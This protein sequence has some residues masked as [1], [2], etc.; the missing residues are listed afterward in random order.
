MLKFITQDTIALGVM[1]LFSARLVPTP[2]SRQLPVQQLVHP[3]QLVRMMHVAWGIFLFVLMTVKTQDHIVLEEMPS[4]RAHQVATRVQ[5]EI[6]DVLRVLLVNMT[7]NGHCV[8]IGL[9]CYCRGAII[10]NMIVIAHTGYYC[11]GGS[12]LTQ[13]A[14]GTYST[15]TSA[16]G[17]ATCVACPIG[18]YVACCMGY[19]FACANDG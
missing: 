9:H 18:S 1:R 15:A 5:Q 10:L 7:R 13:C 11:T 2:L 19:F 6:Q 12:A 3:V 4:I 8:V 16:T 17:A 14:A